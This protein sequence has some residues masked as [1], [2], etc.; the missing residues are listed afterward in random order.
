MYIYKYIY[1][2]YNVHI[3]TYIHKYIY[4]LSSLESVFSRIHIYIVYKSER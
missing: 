1:F 3:F 4:L 2:L